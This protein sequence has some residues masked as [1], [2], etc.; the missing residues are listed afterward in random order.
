MSISSAPRGISWFRP[1]SLN[2]YLQPLLG[3]LLNSFWMPHFVKCS[4]P[5]VGMLYTTRGRRQ[6]GVKNSAHVW[7]AASQFCTLQ[8]FCTVFVCVGGVGFMNYGKNGHATLDCANPTARGN[9]M[10]SG[11]PFDLSH[12]SCHIDDV[13]LDI[14]KV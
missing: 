4:P 1:S 3:I 6:R 12:D 14:R 7:R 13:T 5:V 9:V 11:T 10:A 2:C 8:L